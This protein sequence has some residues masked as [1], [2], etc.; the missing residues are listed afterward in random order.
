MMPYSCPPQKAVRL[1]AHLL[2]D[3]HGNARASSLLR[4]ISGLT[5]LSKVC[6]PSRIR[7][8]FAD[9]QKKIE[10]DCGL[11]LEVPKQG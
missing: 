5:K 7:G 9:C 4:A 10:T 6:R 2:T 3:L 1:G 8:C 11:G